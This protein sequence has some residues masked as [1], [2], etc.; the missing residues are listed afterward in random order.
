MDTDWRHDLERW[1]ELFLE[2]LGITVTVH[3]IPHAK[4]QKC[5]DWVGA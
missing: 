4:A 1:L 5:E 2:E 3:L